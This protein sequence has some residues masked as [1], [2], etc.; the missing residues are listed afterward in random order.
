VRILA[1]DPG[2]AFTG[3]AMI[4]RAVFGDRDTPG[5]PYTDV[6]DARVWTSKPE[7]RRGKRAA[8]GKQVDRARR[9]MALADCIDGR[10]HAWRP[11]VVVAESINIMRGSAANVASGLCWGVLSAVC[12]VRRIPLYSVTVQ[13]WRAYARSGLAASDATEMGIHLELT[14]QVRG[15]SG[16]IEAIRQSQR[17][18]ALDAIGIGWWM[19]NQRDLL[20]EARR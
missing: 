8:T 7:S 3:I 5:L 19:A 9:A 1:I 6:T 14:L 10:I 13:A 2:L 11:D 16:A 17:E 15:A 20:L 18:H 12:Q 4:E